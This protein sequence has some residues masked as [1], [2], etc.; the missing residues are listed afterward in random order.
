MF[1]KK[2]EKLKEAFYGLSGDSIRIEFLSDSPVLSL[3]IIEERSG[4]PVKIFKKQNKIDFIYDVYFDNTFSINADF[5]RE[6]YVNIKISRKSASV[7][8][9]YNQFEITR[10][11]IVV[12]NKTQR[13]LQGTTMGYEK[14]FN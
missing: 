11:S 5:V 13:S 4:R 10:D 8:N 7:E 3:S 6:S 1:L 14:A 12:Q 2:G 9:Y